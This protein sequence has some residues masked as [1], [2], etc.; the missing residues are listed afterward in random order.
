MREGTE[1][2]WEALKEVECPEF[3]ISV[4]DMGMIYDIEEKDGNVSVT[5]TFTTTACACMEWIK[6][7]IRERLMKEPDVRDVV[8]QVVWDPPWTM[9]KLSERARHQLKKVG[10]VV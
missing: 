4:V 5:M 10:V 2:L 8:I 1:A 3:P 9:D 6:E 7:D